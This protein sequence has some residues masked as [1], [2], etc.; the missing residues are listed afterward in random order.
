MKDA[1]GVLEVPGKLDF[2]EYVPPPA[3]A[4]MLI[5]KP[6]EEMFE[7]CV[8]PDAHTTSNP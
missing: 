8:D 1:S 4:Q 3:R 7:A 2:Q 5:R 6:V